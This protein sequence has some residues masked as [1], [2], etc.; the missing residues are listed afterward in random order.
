MRGASSKL[1]EIL[2]G[3]LLLAA[4]G[5]L[6]MH[7]V[8]KSSAI[9]ENVVDTAHNTEDTKGEDPDT[10]NGDNGG[11][12]SVGEPSEDTEESGNDIDDQDGAGQLPRRNG[13]P[14][15]TVGTGN[16][17]E[18]VLSEGDLK[19][20]DL[21]QVTEVLD[22]TAVLAVGVHGGDSDPGADGKDN[23][24]QDGHS[25][26]LGQVPLDGGLAERSVVVGDGQG[27][28]I[29]K[30]GNEDNQLNV[31][32]TVEDGNPETQ[33][34]LEMDGQSDTVDNVGVHAV[35]NLAGSLKSVDDSTKTGGKEDNVG[36]G[37][38]SIGS[39]LDSNTGISLLQR[40]SVVDTVTSHGNEVATLLEN[41]DDVVLV[42]GE[43]LSE[44]IGS[45]NEIVNLR[46]GHVT[47]TTE[48]E[49]LSV[50]DV[51][52]KTELAGSLT[53]NADGITSQHLDGQTESLG[54]VDSLSGIVTR[55]VRARHNSENLP[56]ALTTLAGNTKGT[57][58][59]SS[60]LS[61][62]VLVGLVDLL[63]DGVVLLHSLQDEK[64]GTLNTDDALTLGRLDV[65]GDLLGDGV[66]GE[67]LD[68]LVLGEDRL[69]AGVVLERLEESLVDSI[70]TLLLAGSSQAGSEH[71]VLGLNT[72][73]G[74]RLRQG[75]LVLG[76]GTGLVGAEN[77]DTSQRLN[78]RQL[79]DD[80]LLLG[81]VGSTD[82]HGGGNDGGKT[83]GDT[84]NGDGQGETEDIDNVVGAVEA[85][86]PDDQEGEDDENQQHCADTVED[87]SEVTSAGV[88]SVD[89]SGGATD[90]GVVTGGGNHDEGL[91]TLDGGGSE[92]LVALVLVDSER[93]TSDSRLVDLEESIL[94]DDAAVGGNDSSLL[95]LENITGN[96][97]RGLDLL[98]GA[99]TEDNS[100]QGKSLLQLVDNRTSL[101]FLNETN[102]SVKKQKT[103]DDT[104][105]DPVLK[106]GSKDGSSLHDELNRTDKVHEELEDQVLLLLLHLVETI[107]LA[108]GDDLRLGK[109]GAG[110]L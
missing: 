91:T 52:T 106:T 53:S 55:G 57:E 14:E 99:V 100:L 63:R 40:G 61:N 2:E 93:F 18:P 36:S 64:R 13:S 109:T 45:L 95:N 26:E 72:G 8:V 82:S 39:T 41:L 42:L 107:L 85:G 35:E 86:N 76:Q 15:R 51:G 69:G 92:A 48:T 77:L 50:V 27:S 60:E 62:L 97:F 28:N 74:V 80:S 98:E 30:D 9:L 108:A 47:A 49:A 31:Q 6:A 54:L 43:D 58:T 65:G 1:T 83:D 20:D 16:E 90:E 88:G 46:T 96:D 38:G 3:S 23:T 66:E 4:L 81:E 59:T 19:E 84:N 68:D 7:E 73:D 34:N 89:E 10:D 87:L 101:E 71:E 56:R 24:E 78:S 70:N 32:G 94:G 79:L 105:I 5:R 104:E 25:P 67:E 22:D 17:D 102:T 37:A 75:E 103:A 11:L 110:V 21:V 29:G 12:T 33:V 44:T